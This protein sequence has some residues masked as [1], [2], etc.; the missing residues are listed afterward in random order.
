[1]KI[2]FSAVWEHMRSERRA[3]VRET[4]N[5]SVFIC[6][7]ILA[8]TLVVSFVTSY[9]AHLDTVY[10]TY[11]VCILHADEGDEG[12]RALSSRG[13][14]GNVAVSGYVRHDGDC[15]AG[16]RQDQTYRNGF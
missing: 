5:Y 4:V 10:G 12:V 9:G 3:Y 2:V 11:D 8:V 1:M 16:G 14:R 6:I 7:V 15:F 13:K